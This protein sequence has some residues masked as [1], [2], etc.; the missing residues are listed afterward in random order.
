MENMKEQ[1]GQHKQIN[2]ATKRE[3]L[4]DLQQLLRDNHALVRLFKI[5]LER[6]PNHDHKVVIRVDKQPSGTHERSFN[7][8]CSNNR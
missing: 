6:M 7:F 8:Q 3:F 1:I 2:T 5:T 4:Y